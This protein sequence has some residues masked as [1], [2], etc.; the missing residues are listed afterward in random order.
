MI[1]Q[2]YSFFQPF[3]YNEIYGVLLSANPNTPSFWL[4]L[5]DQITEGNF[6]YI[7]DGIQVEEFNTLWASG[8]PDDFGTGRVFSK[9]GRYWSC[10]SHSNT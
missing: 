4:G 9:S 3:R 7:S 8:Q 6:V 2:H 1:E 5:S 10:N